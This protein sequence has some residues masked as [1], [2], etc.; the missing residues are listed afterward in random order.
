MSNTSDQIEI[1][2]N[3]A[4]RIAAHA[5][6]EKNPDPLQMYFQ[7]VPHETI[8]TLLNWTDDPTSWKPKV[9]PEDRTHF[10]LVAECMLRYYY[11]RFE[12]KEEDEDFETFDEEFF[13]K[14]EYWSRISINGTNE[15]TTVGII[16]KK[17]KRSKRIK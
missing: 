3:I 11:Y 16:K 7:S 12:P 6:E 9:Y 15:I 17:K 5:F 8:R 4:H 14:K 2:N 10:R 1:V 13:G